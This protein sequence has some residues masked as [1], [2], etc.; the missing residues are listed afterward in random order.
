MKRKL[1]NKSTNDNY[2]NGS[3]DNRFSSRYNSRLGFNDN[4][5]LSKVRFSIENEDI[6]D[7]N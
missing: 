4:K 7:D 3:I 6:D 5:N 2:R 1:V